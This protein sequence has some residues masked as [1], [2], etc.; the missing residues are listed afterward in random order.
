MSMREPV[1]IGPV[2]YPMSLG[3]TLKLTLPRYV[4]VTTPFMTAG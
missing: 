1:V 2:A 4:T 3:E